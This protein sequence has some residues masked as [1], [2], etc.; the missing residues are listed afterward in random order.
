MARIRDKEEM[1]LRE[2]EVLQMKV[3]E[4]DS[5]KYVHFEEFLSSQ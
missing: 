4:A 2:L 5:L 3:K 1:E